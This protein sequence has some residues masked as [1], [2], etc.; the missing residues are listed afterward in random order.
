MTLFIISCKNLIL[1]RKGVY[2]IDYFATN[3]IF[4]LLLLLGIDLFVGAPHINILR[5]PM[6]LNRIF[7]LLRKNANFF[8]LIN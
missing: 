7:H 2:L 6:W 4:Y 5:N 1:H 8:I 3:K